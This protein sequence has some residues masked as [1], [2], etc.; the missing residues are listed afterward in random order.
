M[1]ALSDVLHR[2]WDTRSSGLVSAVGPVN[3]RFSKKLLRNLSFSG[4]QHQ[5]AFLPVR[6]GSGS[7]G[8][9]FCFSPFL[10]AFQNLLAP[11]ELA[12]CDWQLICVPAFSPAW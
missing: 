12:P 7:V 9:C 10:S 1:Q 4:I 5:R 6:D 3:A 8:W 2:T 11:E